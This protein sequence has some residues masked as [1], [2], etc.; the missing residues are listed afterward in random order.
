[1]RTPTAYTKR[2]IDALG[3]F[4]IVVRDYALPTFSEPANSLNYA[5][6]NSRIARRE[7]MLLSFL[8]LQRSSEL[9]FIKF[10]PYL[11]RNK[12]ILISEIF[13]VCINHLLLFFA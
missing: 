6:K 5:L 2:W 10:N 1:M 9:L 11:K 13:P 12:Q 3:T 7:S 4:R 8:G